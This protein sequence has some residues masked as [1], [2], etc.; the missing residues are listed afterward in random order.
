MSR[1]RASTRAR[2]KRFRCV[3]ALE[4]LANVCSL[5]AYQLFAR[6]E[7]E[8]FFKQRQFGLFSNPS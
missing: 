2:L 1:E 4:R 3:L 5:Y 8:I 6:P 7:P